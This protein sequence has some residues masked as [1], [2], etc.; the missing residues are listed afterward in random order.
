MRLFRK[1][2]LISLLPCF[3]AWA[4]P[5]SYVYIQGDKSVPFYVKLNGQ[6]QPRY[7]QYHCI[8]PELDSGVIHME[9]LFQQR[10]YPAQKFTVSVPG[11]G[12]IG[13]LLNKKGNS[14]VL[15][16]L[17]DKKEILPE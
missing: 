11:N 6:M 14:F 16:D 1:L 8:I 5:F 17:R 9:I 2:L 4:H 10:M 7:G 3:H 13:F 12:Q 15:Y